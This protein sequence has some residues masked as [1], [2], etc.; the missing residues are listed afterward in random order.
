MGKKYYYVENCDSNNVVNPELFTRFLKSRK[1]GS[2]NPPST[3]FLHGG[4][5]WLHAR[6]RRIISIII[7]W[8]EIVKQRVRFLPVCARWKDATRKINARVII[9][10]R[11]SITHRCRIDIIPLYTK[12][13]RVWHTH[14][15]TQKSNMYKGRPLKKKLVDLGGAYYNMGRG[16]V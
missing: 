5:K 1:Q 6:S 15:Q 9:F 13:A 11:V 4:V 16:G 7:Y 3:I 2:I 8:F 10:W 14:T 12:S